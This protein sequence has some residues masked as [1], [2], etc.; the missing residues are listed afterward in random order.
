[1]NVEASRILDNG[2]LLVTVAVDLRAKG[3]GKRI[4]LPDEDNGD[5]SRQ[6]FLLA[7][8]RGRKWQQA[9]DNGTVSDARELASLIGRDSSYVN[10]I[11]RLSTLAPEIIERVINGEMP[12]NLSANRAR[13]A[14]PDQWSDQVR[15]FFRD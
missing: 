14:I 7:V 13:Q 8:A 12:L 9:L 5:R 4:I 10:R 11:I 2:N 6:A 3:N 15:E 1:M